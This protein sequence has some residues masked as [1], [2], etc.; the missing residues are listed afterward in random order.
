MCGE[1]YACSIVGIQTLHVVPLFQKQQNIDEMD[2]AN[3][4]SSF[5]KGVNVYVVQFSATW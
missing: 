3:T 2:F 4:V 1:E 5:S